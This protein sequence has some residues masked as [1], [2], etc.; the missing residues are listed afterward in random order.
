MQIILKL[1]NFQ[2]DL[3][4]EALALLKEIKSAFSKLTE[5]KN[6]ENFEC[7]R[8]KLNPIKKAVEDL[9]KWFK[10]EDK[11]KKK[12]PT[13]PFSIFDEN[14]TSKK[15]TRGRK[16]KLISSDISSHDSDVDL[17]D[18]NYFYSSNRFDVTLLN[19]NNFEK[20]FNQKLSK[21]AEKKDKVSKYQELNFVSEPKQ[22]SSK[23]ASTNDLVENKENINHQTQKINKNALVPRSLNNMLTKPGIIIEKSKQVCNDPFDIKMRLIEDNELIPLDLCPKDLFDDF[24]AYCKQN[25]AELD[26]LLDWN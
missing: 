24:S 11:T 20:K 15:E 5:H 7:E 18:E 21:K 25:R 22:K 17:I 14:L 2:L 19:K 23:K 16:R 4:K 1:K 10:S 9:N 12:K 6:V 3:I 13:V 8:D 26:S